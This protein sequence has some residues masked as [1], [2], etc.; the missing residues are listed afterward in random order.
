MRTEMVAKDTSWP[1][2]GEI[3]DVSRQRCMI[4]YADGTDPKKVGRIPMWT[5]PEKKVRT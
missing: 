4:R 5:E 2:M 1:K 3:F